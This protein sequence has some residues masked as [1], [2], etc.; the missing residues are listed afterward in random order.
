[1]CPQAAQTLA[2]LQ[3][4]AKQ[5]YLQFQSKS[6]DMWEAAKRTHLEFRSK[7][8]HVQLV[9]ATR[10]ASGARQVCTACI[11]VDSLSSLVFETTF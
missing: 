2:E 8:T 6:T 7:A 3:Q 5:L 9:A 4:T 11:V 10:T 1:M